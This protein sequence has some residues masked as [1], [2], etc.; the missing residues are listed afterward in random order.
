[1]SRKKDHGPN[2]PKTAGATNG[3]PP[4]DLRDA[5]SEPAS[6]APKGPITDTMLKPLIKRFYKIVTVGEGPN[7]PILL[8][9]RAVKT[10]K[11]RA[12]K[13]PTRVLADAVA[14]E[15]AAQ[16]KDINPSAMP[17]TRFANTAIDAVNECMEEVAADIVAYAGS[18]LLCYRA[19]AP[20]DLAAQQATHWDPVIAWARAA[21]DAR[22][23]VV[24]G[25]MPVEQPQHALS[26]MAA[27]LHPHDAFRLTA[28]HVM[29]TLTGSALLTLAH[30]H[31][32]L[33]AEDAWTAAHVDEDYQIALW[34][35]DFEAE[36]RRTRRHAEFLAACALLRS[37][38]VSR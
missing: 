6:G 33:S 29:T 30:V 31:G 15:W 24:T 38:A 12:L 17:L 20:Q 5:L 25:V 35:T 37:L 23:T 10:P 1:M 14:V 27:A 8:D 7:F 2:T 9:G 13:L 19:L 4:G 18:D 3:I 11:K 22:L 32:H 28:Q 16:D 36:H 34:G 21:L 26:A